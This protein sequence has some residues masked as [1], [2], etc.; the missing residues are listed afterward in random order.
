M[1]V[2]RWLL[3]VVGVYLIGLTV[4]SF[5]LATGRNPLPFPDP[6]SRIFAASSVEG[7]DAVVALLEQHGLKERLQANTP[8]VSRTIL[9]DGTIINHSSPEVVRKVGG[10][11][12]CIGLVADDPAAAARDAAAFLKSRG[13][14]GDV[15]LDVEPGMPIAFVL[16]NALSGNCINFRRHVIHMPRPKS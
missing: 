14:T 3:I 6:G 2:P 15:V 12:G 8:G 16:T 7:R 10:A 13:F 5:L 11:T 9:M 1:R 4:W